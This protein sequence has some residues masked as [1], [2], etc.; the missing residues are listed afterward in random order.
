MVRLVIQ[1]DTV[2]RPF[3]LACCWIHSLELFFC[4]TLKRFISMCLPDPCLGVLTLK[5]Q[6]IRCHISH[7]RHDAIL[8]QVP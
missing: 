7:K 3:C 5:M 6:A 4:M 2:R 1:M 8:Y